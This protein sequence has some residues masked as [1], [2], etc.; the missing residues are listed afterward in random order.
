VLKISRTIIVLTC[1]AASVAA[2]QAP[3]QS[4]VA[5]VIRDASVLAPLAASWLPH[6]DI[7]IRDTTITT[8]APAGGSLP[9]AKFVIDGTGKFVIPGLFDN[10][11]RLAELWPHSSALFLVY[12]VTSVR[13]FGTEPGTL[14]Q[15]RRDLANGKAMGPR[16][17]MP[18]TAVTASPASGAGESMASPGRGLHDELLRLV[19][20]GMTTSEALRGATIDSARLQNR[21]AELGSIER[22]KNAD[23]IVLVADPLAD[24]RHTQD[25]DAVVFRGETLTRAH[26]NAMLSRAGRPQR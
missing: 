8:I 12:G 4:R 26:L 22:G 6:R 1:F 11:V 24:I 10:R 3:A 9:D 20:G 17:M 5:V 25:I 23:L 18:F 15:W 2:A 13:D 16:I 19:R 14:D 21:D 7:V